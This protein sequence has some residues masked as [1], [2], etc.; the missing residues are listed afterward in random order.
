MTTPRPDY[1]KERDMQ[2][3]CRLLHYA[4]RWGST[5][6]GLVC[7]KLHAVGSCLLGFQGT[8]KAKNGNFKGEILHIP[9]LKP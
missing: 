9:A 1:G 7:T 3:G 4:C 6:F 5:T 8:I 2:H